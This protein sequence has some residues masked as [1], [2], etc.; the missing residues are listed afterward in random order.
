ME[1]T[2]LVPALVIFLGLLI[3]GGRLWFARTAVIEAAHASAR[4][5]SL[6]R[7]A[8]Q[9]NTEG[10]SAAAA[11]LATVGL[12][13]VDRSIAIGT[14]A[15]SVPVGT[16][17]TVDG[18]DQLQGAVLRHRAAW[19]ARINQRRR[20]GLRCVG[21]LPGEAV[22]IP[23]GDGR[24]Q[25]VSLFVLMII[26]GLIMTAGLVIDGGQK[27][28]AAS[29]AETAAAG[30]SR[31]A[32]NAAATLELGGASPVAAAVTAAKA[33][34]AGQPGVTGSVAVTGGIVTV[35]TSA[36]EPTIFLAAI[37][38]GQVTGRGSAQANL[39]PTGHSR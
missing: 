34:L 5:A 25:S 16:P 3:A 26:G 2:L 17:A 39:V 14:G 6:A 9:A 31:A 21:H 27:V 15:F 13:C 4:A 8:T 18:H 10:Q 33:Y 20:S 7:T 35:Q 11:S 12:V 29:R 32:G 24:G 1:I 22:I 28:A 38:I 30:A 37:G 36:T 23:K 19:H